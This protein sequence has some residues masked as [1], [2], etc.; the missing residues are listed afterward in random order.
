MDSNFQNQNN[1]QQSGPVS[2]TS[3]PQQ[4][5][6]VENV[7]YNVQVGKF[8]SRVGFAFTVANASLMILILVLAWVLHGLA[9]QTFG[10]ENYFVKES[11]ILL[12]AI[13]VPLIPLHIFST[14]RLK[15]LI[16]NPANLE[17]ILFK[18]H[19]RKALWA[20]IIISV[21]YISFGIYKGLS[22]LFLDKE[23]NVA[24]AFSGVIIYGGAFA[25]LAWW[26]YSFQKR[27]QR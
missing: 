3:S 4:P 12:I 9:G 20:E 8:F 27:T 21:Y 5:I 18:K 24:A 26:S 23:G 25:F 16:E 22:I 7:Q 14:K 2:Q 17:D 15:K 13:S 1:V 19:L 10:F 11:I 6:Q